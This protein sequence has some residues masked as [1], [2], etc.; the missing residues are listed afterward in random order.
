MPLDQNQITHAPAKQEPQLLLRMQGITKAFFGNT[1]NDNIDFDLYHNE[2]CALLGE[3]GAGKSSLMKILFGLYKADA[4][5]TLLADQNSPTNELLPVEMR[6]SMT[7][8]FWP[9]VRLPSMRFS[10][11]WSLGDERT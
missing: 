1:A 8:T 11:P 2:I 6:S 10:R 4:G 7:I 5:Q 3:N 9:K